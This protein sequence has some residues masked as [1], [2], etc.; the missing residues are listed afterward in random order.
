MN[1]TMSYWRTLATPS[2]ARLLIAVFILWFGVGF[3]VD[4]LLLNYQPLARGFFWPL[5]AGAAG[6]VVL[7]VRLQRPRLVPV[8]LLLTAIAVRMGV[9]L[10]LHSPAPPDLAATH[11]R[12]LFD[13]IGMLVGTILGYR[14]TVDFIR[15]EGRAMVRLQTELALAHGIQETLVPTLSL[16]AG[17]VE[18]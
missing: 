10:S 1:G 18:I 5:S 13:A 6:A 2:R 16:Q 9:A 12:V 8:F 11:R 4:L 3:I 7:A 17:R 14:L 15:S